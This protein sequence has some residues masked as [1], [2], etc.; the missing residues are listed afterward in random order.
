MLGLMQQLGFLPTPGHGGSETASKQR[1]E[2]ERISNV[3]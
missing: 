1:N 3:A 2:M